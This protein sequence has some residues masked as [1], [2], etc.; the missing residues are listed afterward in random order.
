MRQRREDPQGVIESAA[1]L[2]A[3]IARENARGIDDANIV[4]AGFSQ[5]GAIALYTALRHPK[6]LAGVLALFDL[7]AARRFAGR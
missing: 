3:L 1:Q 7:P 6:R 4:I 5:G 2:E